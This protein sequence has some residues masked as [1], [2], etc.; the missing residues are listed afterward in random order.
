MYRPRSKAFT[1]VE[2]LVVIA[3]IGVLVGL[4]LPAVQAARES[5]RR[6]QCVNS[7]RQL[8]QG[9]TAYSG[10]KE[11]TPPTRY[12]P[13]YVLDQN[14]YLRSAFAGGGNDASLASAFSGTPLVPLNWVHALAPYID[15]R[16]IDETLRARL[17]GSP[18]Q[19]APFTNNPATDKGMVNAAIFSLG[20]KKAIL[21]CPTDG[22]SINDQSPLSYGM[23]GGRPNWYG[24]NAPFDAPINNDHPENGVTQDRLYGSEHAA[25]NMVRIKSTFED[26]SANDGTGQTILFAENYNIFNWNNAEPAPAQA[27][28]P[29]QEF[30]Q[31]ILWIDLATDPSRSQPP[32]WTDI[33]AA[34]TD[35]S[36]FDAAA[37]ASGIRMWEKSS[38]EFRAKVADYQCARPFSAHVQGSNVAF[39]D[40]SVRFFNSRATYSVYC[41]LMTS[42][43]KRVKHP[44]FSPTNNNPAILGIPAWQGT[45]VSTVDIN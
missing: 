11:C 24:G 10:A 18:K 27:A 15:M 3:I 2:L 17:E 42:N 39:C 21:L 28:V 30:R 34:A 45:T 25:F 40:G 19:P 22:F 35:R 12:F 43:G 36:S 20:G 29:G 31:S 13:D 38:G 33:A 8:S 4:L 16:D 32:G 44:G 5:A 26:I 7:L 23:N 37:E 41:Q 9:A 14:G 1:V 6:A